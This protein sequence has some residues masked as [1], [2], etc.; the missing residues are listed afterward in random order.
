VPF[1]TESQ[2]LTER[3]VSEETAEIIER[4]ALRVLLE[5]PQHNIQRKAVY[6]SV[7]KIKDSKVRQ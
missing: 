5:L 3:Q 1:S 6:T 7:D 2:N 4:L